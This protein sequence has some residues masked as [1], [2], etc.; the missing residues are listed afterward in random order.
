MTAGFLG[1]G[2]M[3]F[4]MAANL[5][6]SGLELVV[7]DPD[8]KRLA[9][10]PAGAR[11]A[12]S[13]AEVVEAADTVLTSLPSSESW[14]GLA[15]RVLVP[16]A[17]SG[18]LFVDLGTVV[19]GEARRVAAAL[20]ARGAALVDAPVS[21]GPEGAR[22]AS[23]WIFAGGD[24]GAFRRARPV[25]ELLGRP[26]RITH[27]GGPGAGQ[28]AK[29][30]N[31]LAMGL[32][33][34]GALEAAAFGVRCGLAPAVVH[35]A[36][37]GG[38]DAGERW[39]WYFE[40]LASAVASGGGNEVGVKFRELPYFLREAREGGFALPL[41]AALHAACDAGERI[42]VDDHRPAPSYWHELTH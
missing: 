10:A 25:L 40:G 4:H 2:E 6:R 19:P 17:R 29:G 7:F 34:A 41:A 26:E 9:R 36:V 37:S 15:D 1:L 24:D 16:N 42:V 38:A 35:R 27:C 39:R 3:G 18:Q 20:A 5:A 14:A 13:E 12:A 23:L 31:Q 32:L 30:V 33:A 28:A 22:T 8:A 11:R 21:G